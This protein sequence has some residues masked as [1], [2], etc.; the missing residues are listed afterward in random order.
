[1]D[2]KIRRLVTTNDPSGKAVILLDGSAPNVNIRED[3][4][5]F[6]TLLWVTDTTPPDI[7][8]NNDAANREIGV[9]PPVG[10]SI[11]RIVEFPP[12]KNTVEEVNREEW[13]KEMG[14][15]PGSEKGEAVRHPNMHRTE[16]IDYAVIMTGE[17]D[18]LLDD[19]DVHLKAGD[20]IVQRAS[21]HAWVNRG[22][23]P[24]RIAFILI[25]AG[26]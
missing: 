25:D 4:G 2:H 6:S 22:D 26:G 7:S 23:E 18:L 1:M 8:S 9:S 14:L 20:V 12:E 13:L 5:F 19:S 15:E 24:C 3:T 11:F 16:S 21:N 17:I 10:G